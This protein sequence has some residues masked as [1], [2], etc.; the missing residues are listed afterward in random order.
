MNQGAYDLTMPPGTYE[1]LLS[2]CLRLFPNNVRA[3]ISASSVDPQLSLGRGSEAAT[4]MDDSLG[5]WFGNK[6][7][8]ARSAS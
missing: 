2:T 3:V 4:S 7:R 8:C 6:L 5:F 1:A